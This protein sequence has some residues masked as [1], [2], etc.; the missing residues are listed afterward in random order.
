MQRLAVIEQVEA[1]HQWQQQLLAVGQLLL[2]SLLVAAGETGMAPI[3]PALI[4]LPWPINGHLQLAIRGKSCLEGI[5]DLPIVN[6]VAQGE[7]L[8]LL[9]ERRLAGSVIGNDRQLGS[10]RQLHAGQGVGQRVRKRPAGQ[11]LLIVMAEGFEQGQHAAA[12]ALVIWDKPV[13]DQGVVLLLPLPDQGCCQLASQT[14]LELQ[15]GAEIHGRREIEQQPVRL[16]Q[17]LAIEAGIGT[18][19]ACGHS[20]VDMAYLVTSLIGAQLPKRE[21]G[22]AARFA[23][24]AAASARVRWLPGLGP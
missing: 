4:V 2:G 17:L 12:L 7:L 8:Q 16:I 1:L 6:I 11:P 13:A 3:Q 14:R 10:V 23:S 15:R 20:P 21:S 9:T 22:G 5:A 24:F 19:E 18:T